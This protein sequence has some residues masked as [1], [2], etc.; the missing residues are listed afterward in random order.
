M[1]KHGYESIGMAFQGGGS[2]GAYH[3]GAYKALSEGSY[4]PDVVS[5]ISIGA[6]TAAI[7]AGN[8]PQDRLKSLYGFWDSIAWP[9]VSGFAKAGTQLK[10]FHNTLSSIQGFLFGQPNFFSPRLPA[11]QFYPVGSTEATSYYDTEELAST[12]KKFVNFDRINTSKTRLLL[13]SVRVK[14]SVLKFFDSRHAKDNNYKI[15]PEH[16]MASGA[17]P[18]GFPGIRVDGDLYWDGGCISNTPLKGIYKAIPDMDMLVFMIDLFNPIGKEPEDMNDVTTRY[19]D[20]LYSSRTFDHIKYIN[21]RHNLACALSKALGN[22]NLD[23]DTYAELK[24]MLRDKIFDIVH[25]VYDA[26]AFE[27]PTKDCEFSKSSIRERAEHGYNDMVKA[28]RESPWL[29]ERPKGIASLFSGFRGGT[30]YK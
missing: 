2:L 20:I 27:V 10:R 13:G 8:E 30:A 24:F 1:K 18:P 15:G 17:M 3:I 19:K 7:I 26:P 29:K 25:I 11:P 23:S 5:G 6:F 4:E 22:A 14:D 9:D 16:V 28:L 12:L 21:K